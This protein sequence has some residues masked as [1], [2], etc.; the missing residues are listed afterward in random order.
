MFW[1]WR[2]FLEGVVG[3]G[4]PDGVVA[5]EVALL[6]L[7]GVEVLVEEHLGVGIGAEGGG[8]EHGARRGPRSPEGRIQRRA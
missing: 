7:L 4:V 1:F 3:E 5:L 2:N 6:G 8:D